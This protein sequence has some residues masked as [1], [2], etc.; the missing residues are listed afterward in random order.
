MATEA[1]KPSATRGFSLSSETVGEIREF[2]LRLAVASVL[3]TALVLYATPLIEML[4]ARGARNLLA[5]VS[6][7]YYLKTIEFINGGYVFETW[8]GPLR[9]A[10]KLPTLLFT[11]GFP[12]GYAMALPGVSTRRYWMRLLTV[13]LISYFVCTITVAL[14][15]DGRLTSTFSKI[16]LSLQ[17][18]WRREFARTAQQ[19]MWMFTMR[20]YPLVMVV[21]MALLSGQFRRQNSISRLP[22]VRVLKGCTAGSLTLLVI[23]CVGFDAPASDR[24]KAVSRQS[25]HDRL[26]GLEELNEDLGPGLVKLAEW[27][28]KQGNDRAAF[29]AYRLALPHLEGKVMIEARQEQ[30]Y[31][32]ERIKEEM[33]EKARLRR[34]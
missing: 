18:E 3:I 4:I 29:N 11:F 2:A 20:L 12:I 26:E 25:I 30:I 17:P 9:G 1:E 33:L 7:Q 31:V 24:I 6:S 14:I 27:L 19:Y 10:F 28:L 32:H 34:N 8:I 21:A 5:L 13:V 22:A 16:G 23:A 15:C